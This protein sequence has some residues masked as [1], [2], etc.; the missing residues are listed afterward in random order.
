MA[1]CML[2]INDL[3]MTLHGKRMMDVSPMRDACFSLHAYSPAHIK[4]YGQP[5][6]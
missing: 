6:Q 1:A 5:R 2:T 3:Y 4:P